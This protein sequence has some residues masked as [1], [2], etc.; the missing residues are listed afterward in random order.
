MVIHTGS[1]AHSASY[2]V[3]TVGFHRGD[4]AAGCE[5]DHS[6]PSSDEVIIV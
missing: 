5:A 6:L 2:P 1:G 3:G 4:K